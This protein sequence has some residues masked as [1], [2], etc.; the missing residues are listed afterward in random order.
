MGFST[1]GIFVYILETFLVFL[2]SLFFL[3]KGKIFLWFPA[4]F[5]LAVFVETLCYYYKLNDINNWPVYNWWFPLEFAFFSIWIRSYILSLQ[6]RKSVLYLIFSYAF[7]VAIRN[8][9]YADLASFNTLNFAFGV[10]LLLLCIF[11][12][13]SEILKAEEIVNPLKLP[14]FWPLSGMLVSN[15][16]SIFH[17]LSNNYLYKSNFELL[18]ALRKINIIMSCFL[19]VTFIVYFLIQW[20]NRKQAI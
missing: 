9:F 13:L 16:M 8:V 5:L 6:F 2:L 19:Y 1:I 4:F 18:S 12:K 15:L 11:Y 14:V 7:F 3:K 20:K 10:L 17:L